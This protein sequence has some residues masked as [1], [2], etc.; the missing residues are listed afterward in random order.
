MSGAPTEVS[1]E[2]LAELGIVV[3]VEKD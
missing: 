3:I 1:A 2:Q